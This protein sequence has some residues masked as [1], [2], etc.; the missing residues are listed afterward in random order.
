MHVVLHGRVRDNCAFGLRCGDL[1]SIPI[2]SKVVACQGGDVTTIETRPTPH[3]GDGEL[4]L[5]LRVVGFC[6]T[7]L[8]KLDTDAARPGMV[9]GHELVGDVVAKGAGVKGFDIGDRIAVPHHVPCGSCVLCQR[10]AETMCDAF[11]ENLLTPGGFAEYLTVQPRAVQ[12]SAYKLPP[13]ISDEAAVFI[14]P[15]A[16]VMRGID[17]SGLV[18]GAP[19]AILGGGSMGL[20]HLLLIRAHLPDSPVLLI[21]PVAERRAVA[22]ELGA[23]ATATPGSDALAS[24]CA[25]SGDLGVDTVFDTVGGAT[26][27]NASLELSRRGGSVVLFAHAPQGQQASFDLND[28]FKYERRVLGTYSGA[29][30]EQRAVYALLEDGKFDPTPLITHRMPLNDFQRGVELVRAR[31]ALK[32][33]FTPTEIDAQ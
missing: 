8:F 6:G 24:A 23:T 25:L 31:K 15:A 3:V 19:A 30:T 7:D 27:L 14:E 28:L 4:L 16:C 33:L 22:S 1:L 11:R 32:V 29:V 17:R 13:H 21:D 2:I 18:N 12:H 20:L 10:G 26:T 5:A 9:L